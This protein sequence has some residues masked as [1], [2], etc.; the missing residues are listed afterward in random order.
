MDKN[1]WFS[2]NNLSIILDCMGIIVDQLV[3][4]Y[5]G[6]RA[7]KG[8]S[9]EVKENRIHGFL[10]PNGAGKSTTMNIM[11]GLVR[12]NSGRVV[13]NG[14]D[15]LQ[16]PEA[17][18]GDIGFL[19]EIPPI[20]ED[21]RVEEF[22][23]FVGSINFLKDSE[24]K[25]KVESI[26]KEHRLEQVK[27]RYISVLSKGFKQRVALASCLVFE[28]KILILDEPTVGLDPEA[29]QEIRNMILKLK[30]SHT[31]LVSSHQLGEISKICDDITIIKDGNIVISDTFEKVMNSGDENIVS[32]IVSTKD[33]NFS[34]G[35][36]ISEKD[37]EVL[38]FSSKAEDES[39]IYE[40]LIRI[41]EHSSS[42]S[43]LKTLLENDLDIVQYSKNEQNLEK[44]FLNFIRGEQ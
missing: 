22:L 34:V 10:G 11:S 38:G 29:I 4:E 32:I 7:L 36:I 43:L 15:T 3:K 31:I 16:S 8:I 27:D 5:P 30:Q 6:S 35:K 1:A 19:P 9:F 21:M 12:Q 40:Y 13:V 18:R 24:L 28:P 33:E 20:Y 17:A 44:T 23:T 2:K 14:K 42:N 37:F 25:G 41:E 39:F 26:L